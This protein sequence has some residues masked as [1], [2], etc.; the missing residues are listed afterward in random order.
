MRPLTIFAASAVCLLW[1]TNVVA[2]SSND[3]VGNGAHELHVTILKTR[4]GNPVVGPAEQKAQSAIQTQAPPTSTQPRVSE[5]WPTNTDDRVTNTENRYWNQL[6][7]RYGAAD[8]AI[9]RNMF[10]RAPWDPSLYRQAVDWLQEQENIRLD[11]QRGN[12]YSYSY[13]IR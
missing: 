6:I 10:P 1:E 2:Q 13:R 11:R 5:H 9:A 8:T 12:S 7:D 4:P 3:M